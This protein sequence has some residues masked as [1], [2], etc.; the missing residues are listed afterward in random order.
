MLLLK[1]SALGGGFSASRHN[2]LSSAESIRPR[3]FRFA[4]N[5]TLSFAFA[6]KYRTP[7]KSK[8]ENFKKRDHEKSKVDEAT[9][10]AKELMRVKPNFFV[11]KRCASDFN[12]ECFDFSERPI[13]ELRELN[14]HIVYPLFG[15]NGEVLSFP[16]CLP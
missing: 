4:S 3:A 1:H 9:E 2:P 11:L 14:K 13:Y 15:A 5:A 12:N 10:K 16:R 7:W 8:R 6:E